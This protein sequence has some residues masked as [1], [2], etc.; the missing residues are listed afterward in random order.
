LALGSK[1]G[2]CFEI[3]FVVLVV[4]EI[5]SP[6]PHS[7]E[8]LGVLAWRFIIIESILSPAFVHSDEMCSPVI[9]LDQSPC[10]KLALNRVGLAFVVA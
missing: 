4:L 8:K 10:I 9:A 2:W 7:G 1:S 5:S 6:Y 3:D